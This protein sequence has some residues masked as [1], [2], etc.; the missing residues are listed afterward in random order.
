MYITYVRISLAAVR[1][2]FHG[3]V[4]KLTK[5]SMRMATMPMTPTRTCPWDDAMSWQDT[6]TPFDILIKF[7]ATEYSYLIQ[8]SNRIRNFEDILFD[9]N[10]IPNSS[11][12][13]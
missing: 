9:S 10:E 7:E 4:R 5:R 12:S 2:R 8:Y 13:Y 3:Y 1:S 6:S 11:H